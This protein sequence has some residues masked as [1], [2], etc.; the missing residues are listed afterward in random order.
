VEARKLRASRNSREDDE[1]FFCLSTEDV[2]S[3]PAISEG[4]R[5]RNSSEISQPRSRHTSTSSGVQMATAESKIFSVAVSQGRAENSSNTM[6]NVVMKDVEK[7]PVDRPVTLLAVTK[8]EITASDDEFKPVQRDTE[9]LG[10]VESVDMTDELES[11]ISQA[12]DTTEEEPK[13]TK[14]N[15][16][17]KKEA[18]NPMDSSA[19][20]FKE[21]EVKPKKKK[22]KKQDKTEEKEK[23]PEPA[24]VEKEKSPE[25]SP[26][27]KEKTPEPVQKEKTPEREIT[28]QPVP[29]KSKKAKKVE[30][31]KPK[32]EEKFEEFLGFEEE[33][34]E[35]CDNK[36]SSEGFIPVES[37]TIEETATD[38]FEEFSKKTPPSKDDI[39]PNRDL[40]EFSEEES[41]RV[42]EPDEDY[43]D[44]V[45]F[46]IKEKSSSVEP[47]DS[48][49]SSGI[50]PMAAR[51]NPWFEKFLKKGS[52]M[53]EDQIFGAVKKYEDDD[54]YQ[55]PEDE[56]M[57]ELEKNQADTERNIADL[58]E[59][60]DV[61]TEAP[62]PPPEAITTP[63]V[64]SNL[65]QLLKG[66]SS[67]KSLVDD[68][69]DDD[70][71]FRPVP[72]QKKNKKQKKQKGQVLSLEEFHR[73]PAP[74]RD[75]DSGSVADSE[76]EKVSDQEG[77]GATGES[78]DGWSFE[79]DEEDVNKLL[80]TEVL[81]VEVE[82]SDEKTDL[83]DVFRF[84]SEMRDD[85][86]DE[87]GEVAG[88]KRSVSVDDL[89][90][91]LM[92][93]TT[94]ESEAEAAAVPIP[95]TDK[96]EDLTSNNSNTELSKPAL[97]TS[98]SSSCASSVD[99]E[100]STTNSPNPRTTQNKNKNKK[101]KKKK[102]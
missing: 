43:D 74:T 58:L 48:M 59:D 102:K 24:Q 16:K 94:D 49:A 36:T 42:I 21:V 54:D 27:I 26:V 1:E 6:R 15:K 14:K 83:E 84:D 88:R 70:F 33:R 4:K 22:N 46:F 13:K 37:P 64:S 50:D 41:A 67:K 93:E 85:E 66:E 73:A 72:Q 18:E 68:S 90:D 23:S 9:V 3:T 57:E 91:A 79:V 32:E 29:R 77:M 8:Q 89:N 97:G 11:A 86:D 69:S 51:P 75:Q 12:T 28:P 39:S 40:V 34:L 100:S 65:S 82:P 81:P 45:D 17:K 95:K 60:D 62:P 30:E 19:D 5:T 96:E 61:P 20:D 99:S 10:C 92:E 87:G 31:E 2:R 25:P 56:G 80:E 101:G 44:S 76:S 35:E 98:M 55:E 52:S 53:I 38:M 63:P 78:R 47:E 71:M 7:Q